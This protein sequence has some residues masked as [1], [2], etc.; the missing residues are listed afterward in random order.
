MCRLQSRKG[1]EYYQYLHDELPKRGVRSYPL[2]VHYLTDIAGGT[3]LGCAWL[4]AVLGAVQQAALA[5][6]P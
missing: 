2:G 1:L 4:C 5:R 6:V 3:L